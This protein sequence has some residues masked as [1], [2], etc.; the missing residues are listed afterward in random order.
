M[1]A[2]GVDAAG[3]PAAGLSLMCFEPLDAASDCAVIR[4]KAAFSQCVNG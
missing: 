2:V 1:L 3:E 4:D